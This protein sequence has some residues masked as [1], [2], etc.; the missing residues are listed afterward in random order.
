MS[1]KSFFFFTILKRFLKSYFIK[2]EVL[3]N[4]VGKVYQELHNTNELLLGVS[5][6]LRLIQ[7]FFL[8]YQ[9]MIDYIGLTVKVHSIKMF[10]F[11]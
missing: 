4:F 3:A 7:T 5:Y 1:A 2:C 6:T 9:V 10:F 8:I 11:G